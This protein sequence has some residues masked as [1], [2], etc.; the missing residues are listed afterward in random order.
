MGLLLFTFR[1]RQFAAQ[2]LFIMTITV[3]VAAQSLVFNI[4]SG[5]ARTT[6]FEFARQAQ[7]SVV[8][9]RSDIE[10]VQTNE[11]S[12]LLVPRDALMQMLEGT[13]LVF[14]ED[15]ETGAIA[16][17]RSVETETVNVTLNSKTQKNNTD[18][19]Q[20]EL[21]APKNMVS[22]F[23]TGL[24][25]LLIIGNAANT[26]AQDEEDDVFLLSPFVVETSDEVGYAATNT[27]AGTRV[28]T[29]LDD[30]ANSI[31]VAT[32][33]LINDLGVDDA[34][35]LLPFLGNIE[36]SGIGG[37]FGG[38]SLSR[39]S[40]Y[41]WIN[42]NPS[43]N[44]RIRGLA[45]A[46]NTRS[47]M[48]T[49]T[50]FDSYNIERVTVNRGPNST[51]FGLGSPGGIIDH[52]IIQPYM[53]NSNRFEFTVG[54]F[55]LFRANFDVQRT[56]L[57]D[58]LGIRVAGLSEE[59][60]FRQSYTYLEDERITFALKYKP[61][62]NANLKITFE[63]GGM[64]ANRP[65]P[66]APRDVISRW[67]TPQFNKLT[68]DPS[69]VSFS[70]VNRDF[71]RAPGEWFFQPAMIY[72]TN[73]G[74]NPSRLNQAW[75]N[76]RIGPGSSGD[77]FQ[78]FTLSI[79]KGDQWFPTASANT[80]D[81]SFYGTEELF[82]RSA[83]DWVENLLDGPNKR[84]WENFDI[85]NI[86]YDQT[87]QF[88]LGSAGFEVSHADEN[89]DRSWYD[90]LDGGRGYTINIDLNTHLNW[91]DVN[92]NFGRPFVAGPNR[93]QQ[94]DF[95]REVQ[96]ATAFYDVDFKNKDGKIMKW[97]GR[98]V[99]TFF[100]QRYTLTNSSINGRNHVDS[101]YLFNATLNPDTGAG[102]TSFTSGSAQVRS[103]VYIGPSVADR[104]SIAGA[105]IQG[106]RGP[107]NY[108]PT[109][110]RYF[111]EVTDTW[112]DS[113]V[114]PTDIRND[115]SFPSTI[116]SQGLS[117]QITDSYAYI[118]QAYLFDQEWLVGTYGY[119]K[120]SVETYSSTFERDSN[121]M[122]ILDSR[123]LN[124]EPNDAEFE[125]I[126]RN[127]GLVA[128]ISDLITLPMDLGLSLHWGE[129]ENFQIS[130]PRQD[131]F[132]NGIAPPGGSTED[133]GFTVTA[134]DNKWSVR[135]NFYESSSERAGFGIP[136]FLI[137][138]DRRIIAYNSPEALAAAGYQGPPQFYRDLTQWTVV[139]DPGTVSGFSV[140][141]DFPSV[142]IT[143]TQSTSS[144]GVEINM[145]YNPTS[146]WRIAANISQQE[147]SLSN[148]APGTQEYLALRI[149]EW[150]TG[151]TSQLISDESGLPVVD[152]VPDTLLNSLNSSLAREGAVVNELR[153]WRYNVISNYVF[154]EDSAL[155][156]FNVGGSFS[157]E[158]EKA[159]GY[160][161]I[162]RNFDGEVLRVPDL[163]NPYTD[164]G[165]ST[166]NFWVGYNR[167]IF[168][169]KVNW[170]LQL[171]VY[172]LFSDGEVLTAQA[173]PNGDPQSVYWREGRT[174]RLKSTFEF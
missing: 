143:D 54:S 80:P 86:S 120:D 1:R 91:G 4:K 173:Q 102:S 34:T 22:R 24:T 88:D 129:G 167:P 134:P 50:V 97:F 11:V 35:T 89:L 118:H 128:H 171:N 121:R 3:Q 81:G 151:P 130:N 15:L 147:A 122:V 49:G 141:Q 79:T 53:V 13:N 106:I 12:G 155:K 105:N 52:T 69:T 77:L 7:L 31:T 94:I 161:L 60:E 152:R 76:I 21:N 47:Y 64:D 110:G 63:N 73:N 23:L 70:T 42:R 62:S 68:H 30:L 146:N 57:D 40:R 65:R 46:D 87:W 45:S 165:L 162:D 84:E 108:T 19:N 85:L 172:N 25:A 27:L 48:P 67:F 133:Y 6:L 148:I 153:E 58:K 126:T 125:A 137:E 78:A 103:V 59:T 33:E 74:A 163:D 150:T 169:G 160:P 71:Y 115:S 136:G 18:M 144:E 101:D 111:D 109:T 16:V 39:E 55:G 138:T 44:N 149:G 142:G 139:E 9:D 159:I 56:F 112:V 36:T 82:D 92:P 10:G 114:T 93:R 8:M 66:N 28:N 157:H 75:E 158:T 90:M 154:A 166:F 2:L 132:G 135:V 43:D 100:G 20:K 107:L 26:N 61:F 96:R 170:R 113:P 95:V 117:R 99:G 123:R 174:W 72:E 116:Y 14:K 124:D 127:F 51:L 140:E 104:N 17:T 5:E 32:R 156:G 38:G 145:I 168:D 83:F 29:S 41:V 119:R 37:S 98:H 131:L 164:D